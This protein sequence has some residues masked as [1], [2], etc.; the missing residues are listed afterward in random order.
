MNYWAGL[1]N[2]SD[3]ENIKVGADSL[4]RLAAAAAATSSATE[5]RSTG[6]NLRITDE[7]MAD[8]DGDNMETDDAD[9]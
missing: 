2:P 4:R 3:V 5:R 9:A 6:R 7:E 8:H 1:H